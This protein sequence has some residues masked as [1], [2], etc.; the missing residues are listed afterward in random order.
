MCGHSPPFVR[1]VSFSFTLSIFLYFSALSLPHYSLSF[2]LS[3]NFLLLLARTYS[4]SFVGRSLFFSCPSFCHIG[5][6]S[7]FPLFRGF[8]SLVF[9][10]EI[11]FI[12]SASH[13]GWFMRLKRKSLLIRNPFQRHANGFAFFIFNYKL[14]FLLYGIAKI[15]LLLLR[16]GSNRVYFI[17]NIVDLVLFW[18]VDKRICCEHVDDLRNENSYK[19][20]WCS[21]RRFCQFVIFFKNFPVGGA[22]S[23]SKIKFPV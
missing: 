17:I 9:H 7:Q 14:C 21:G 3:S 11:H 19:N 6:S 18:I 2:F 15:V 10:N 8:R 4:L 5:F 13:F 20:Y 12:E 22:S 23:F 1:C 16:V